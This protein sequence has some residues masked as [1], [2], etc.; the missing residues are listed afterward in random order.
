MLSCSV[1]IPV[2]KEP[3][4]ENTIKNIIYEFRANKIQTEVIL[5]VDK[6]PNDDTD[7]AVQGIAKKYNEIQY[8]IR[9]TKKG[10]AD[11]IREGIKK[12]RNEISIIVMA[13][14]SE[15]PQDLVNIVSKMSEGYDMVMGNRFAKGLK[16]KSYPKK[17]LFVN[18]LC[19]KWRGIFIKT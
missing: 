13:D 16:M 1:I 18:R 15:K 4:I 12:A 17:K 11:A 8:S 9:D 3:E 7:I 14:G 19:R 10:V 6:A 2:Y 5:I